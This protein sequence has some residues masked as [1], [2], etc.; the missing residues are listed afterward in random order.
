VIN[1]LPNKTDLFN[2]V[3][4]AIEAGAVAATILDSI[5]PRLT[6]RKLADIEDIQAYED[7]ATLRQAAQEAAKKKQWFKTVTGGEL[8]GDFVFTSP[9]Q[10]MK[11]TDFFEKM[12]A[13]EAWVLGG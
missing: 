10:R 6:N 5:N 2:L 4:K 1:D 7:D 9:F 12:K 3:Q 8:L 11:Q 13:L